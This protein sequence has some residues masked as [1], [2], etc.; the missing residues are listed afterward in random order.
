M[1]GHLNKP[2]IEAMYKGLNKYYY[3]ININYKTNEL[4]QKMLLNLYKQKWNDG[5]KLKD[6]TAITEHSHENFEKVSK[7]AV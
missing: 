4:D 5:L 1:T 6:Q 2:S 7:W 3:S